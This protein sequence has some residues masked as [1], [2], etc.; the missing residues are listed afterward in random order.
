MRTIVIGILLI[1]AVI[2]C[3]NID[4]PVENTVMTSYGLRKSDGGVDTL[5][6][7]T[8]WVWMKRVDHTDTLFINSLCGANATGF[9]IPIS[10]TQP[11]DSIRIKVVDDSDNEWWDTICIK[12]DNMPHFESVDCQASYFHTLTGVKS[13]HHLIDTIVI[14]NP[15]VNY[16]TSKQHL[17]LYLKARH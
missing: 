16:D 13:T 10:Y 14:N 6:V 7:D 15:D 9:K 8:M 2:S 3:T 17:H 5:G 4:C 12:K 11:E 1:V